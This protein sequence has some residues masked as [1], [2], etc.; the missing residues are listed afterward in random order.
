MAVAQTCLKRDETWTRLA[1]NNC[2]APSNRASS[3]AG[4]AHRLTHQAFLQ[5][6]NVAPWQRRAHEGSAVPS[7]VGIRQP[8]RRQVV[9]AGQSGQREA[10]A[11]G[12]A[13]SSPRIR[14]SFSR[15]SC[16]ATSVEPESTASQ[17]S[18][19]RSNESR[20][21]DSTRASCF[22][23]MFK[24]TLMSSPSSARN[25]DSI[26][27]AH[28]WIKASSRSQSPSAAP[29]ESRVTF[30]NTTSVHQIILGNPAALWP[31]LFPDVEI[32]SR[33]QVPPQQA[34]VL[35]TSTKN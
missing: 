30:R 5:R 20:Q 15:I 9:V 32:K 14:A 25:R 21:R 23:I 27:V 4:W 2:A 19:Y 29:S 18:M 35:P 6:A 24:H 28:V 10:P 12:R 11:D 34:D 3:G 16:W 1:K 13:C 22:T 31:P 33:G 8:E 7:R 26:R 17:V